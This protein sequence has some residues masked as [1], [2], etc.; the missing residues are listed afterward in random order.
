MAPAD[1]LVSPLANTPVPPTCRDRRISPF[2]PHSIWNTPIG[3][4]AVFVPAG[5]YPS[6]GSGVTR[7]RCASVRS[8]EQCQ[9]WEVQEQQGNL[10]S[11]SSPGRSA[12]GTTTMHVA[13]NIPPL[14]T[15]AQCANQTVHWAT[16]TT[17]PGAFAGITEAQC[18]CA[19]TVV[20]SL[21]CQQNNVD[22]ML[23]QH[24]LMLLLRQPLLHRDS[25]LCTSS[26]HS[27]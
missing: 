18:T 2:G 17:C 3:S 10:S 25:W 24:Q 9:K 11:T 8:G 21:D 22:Y 6:P 20:V 23:V 7:F 15:P 13:P 27:S 16:R 14:P 12:I 4:G 26:N 1:V 19:V 5:I